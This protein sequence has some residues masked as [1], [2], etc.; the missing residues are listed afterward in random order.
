M[1]SYQ[2]IVKLHSLA[3]SKLVAGETGLARM[4]RWVHFIDLPDVI[5]WVQ[6]GELLI[7]TGIGLEGDLGRLAPL[8]AGIINKDLAGLIV[9]VGPYIDKV[10][11]DV[12]AIANRAGFPVFELPWEVKLVEVTQEICSCIVMKHLVE[13]SISD[14][15][16]QLLLKPVDD[17]DALIHRAVAFHYDLSLPQQ[18]AIVSLR[19]L[20]EYQQKQGITAEQSMIA[21][22]MHMER[23]VRDVL[24][25]RGKTCLSMAWMDT[26]VLLM[27]I[28]KPVAGSRQNMIILADIVEQLAV[29]FPDLFPAVGLGKG[30]EE[31]CDVRQSYLQANKALRL[32]EFKRN[33]RPI[34]VYEQLGIYKLLFDIPRE[35]LRSYYQDVI[36]PL[37][38]YDE[39]YKSDLVASLFVYFEENG[40]VVQTAKRL[41]VH[42]NT[43]DYR[44]KKIEDIT[45]KKLSDSYDCLTLQLG[46]VIGKQMTPTILIDEFLSDD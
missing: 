1:I 30:V 22:K 25:R 10:P 13:R 32:A 6:G 39:K 15:L 9:N 45:G 42:R 18:V 2:D 41:F 29:R 20:A 8:V 46:V 35:K 3:K 33:S 27:P 16:E 40:N 11:D 24:T 14:F 36:G 17:A 23:I 43:L 4:V 38:E 31:L 7:I 34:Y 19:G 5:P 37:N 12:I 28:A 44:L 26:I 21:L